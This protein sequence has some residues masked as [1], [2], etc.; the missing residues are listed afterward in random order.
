MSRNKINLKKIDEKHYELDVRGLVCPFPQVM[1]TRV[2][3]DL[4]EEKILEVIIDNPPSVRDIPPAL[5]RKGYK[6][7][8]VKIDK[9]ISKIVIRR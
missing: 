7:K 8:I 9:I 1:V 2:L 3:E 4:T 5:E 6:S